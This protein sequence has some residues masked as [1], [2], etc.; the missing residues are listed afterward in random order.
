[1]QKTKNKKTK[2]K[3]ESALTRQHDQLINYSPNRDNF[4]RSFVIQSRGK[5]NSI[6]LT[7]RLNNILEILRN[8]STKSETIW[9]N[10]EKELQ[11]TDW[12]RLLEKDDAH[13]ACS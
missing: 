3:R 4:S 13:T 12:T 7:R 8:L 11:I 9:E 2:T 5:T 1:M 10:T 6:L